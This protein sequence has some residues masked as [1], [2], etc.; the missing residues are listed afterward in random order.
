[1]KALVSAL[2]LVCLGVGLVACGSSETKTVTET[3]KSE[4]TGAA[5]TES[6]EAVESATTKEPTATMIPDGT[7]ERGEYTPGTYRARGGSL[8]SW[9]KRDK[10]GEEASG[11]GNWG[12]SEKNILAEIDSRYFVTEGCGVWQKVGG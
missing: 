11:T 4:A 7:W 3:V 1:M 10:L 8:C 12:G 6:S 5:Q 9:E 2:V